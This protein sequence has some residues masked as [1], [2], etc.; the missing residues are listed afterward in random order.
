MCVSFMSNRRL[1]S[2]I[3]PR[4][5]ETGVAVIA[6]DNSRRILYYYK[7]LVAEFSCRRLAEITSISYKKDLQQKLVAEVSTK[8]IYSNIW[9]IGTV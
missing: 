4:G 8:L 9:T 1:I 7:T 6:A 3:H 2:W 5:S